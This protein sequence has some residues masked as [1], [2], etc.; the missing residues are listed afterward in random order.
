MNQSSIYFLVNYFESEVMKIKQAKKRVFVCF[1]LAAQPIET[2][3]RYIVRCPSFSEGAEK[4]TRQF[5]GCLM[6]Q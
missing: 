3:I 4:F 2:R 6:T 1:P 5:S